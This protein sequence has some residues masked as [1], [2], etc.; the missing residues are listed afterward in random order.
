MD[1]N[2]KTM[3]V[4]S[5]SGKVGC[6]VDEETADTLVTYMDMVLEK[7]RVMNL[8][9]IRDERAF[10]LLNIIDSLSVVPFI[11]HG[12]KILDIGTG[13]GLPGMVIAIAR[14]DLT[15]TMLDSTA[16]KLAFVDEAIGSLG[17]KNA[18]TLCGRAEELSRLSE[19]RESFDAAVSRAV[20]RLPMLSEYALPFVRTGGVFIAMKGAAGETEAEEA[21]SVVSEMGGGLIRR[22]E[23]LLPEGEEKRSIIV[24]AKTS[25]TPSSYPRRQSVLKKLYAAGSAK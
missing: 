11:P 25:A 5:M 10:I 4:M 2:E 24:V 23:L 8:T 22:E 13:A 18:V 16:K 20:A 7:N 19:Y 14:K 1:R 3:L 17:L 21:S 15:V 12:M 9:A 6:T